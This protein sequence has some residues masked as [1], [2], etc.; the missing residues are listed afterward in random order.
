MT[1][2]FIVPEAE[3]IRNLA[4][5][6]DS[7]P[8]QMLNLI[9]F[10][11]RALEPAEGMTGAEAYGTYSV[12]V[13]PILERLGGRVIAAIRCEDGVIGPVE[14]EWDMALIVEYPSAAAF[15]EMVGSEDYLQ[16]HRF[17][18]AGLADSR[19]VASTGLL[20]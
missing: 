8:V 7:G 14:P 13:A 10:R 16:T 1:G 19:L 15:L 18:E 6:G 4:E 3:Q 11:D 17:R 20:A 9:R 5:R 12:E 2:P